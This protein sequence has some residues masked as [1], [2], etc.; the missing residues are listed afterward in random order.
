MRKGVPALHF[1]HPGAD[2]EGKSE[3]E[4]AA[5]RTAYVSGTYHKVTDEATG[6]LRYDGAVD[7]ARLI[8]R[9]VLDVAN[10]DARPTWR[11][12]ITF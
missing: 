7:D 5:L 10:A 1:L 8:T 12:P 6:A 9:V 11:T 4:S 3:A 2:Y